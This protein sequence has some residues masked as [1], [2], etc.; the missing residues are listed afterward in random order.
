MT[1]PTRPRST[2]PASRRPP[3]LRDPGYAPPN[4]ATQAPQRPRAANPPTVLHIRRLP[5]GWSRRHLADRFL[6]LDGAEGVA[7]AFHGGEN[8]GYLTFCTQAQAL[9]ACAVVSVALGT[10]APPP[11]R[12]PAA[13]HCVSHGV[14]RDLTVHAR[15]DALGEGRRDGLPAGNA[16]PA[17]GPPPSHGGG[18]PAPYSRCRTRA[19]TSA[20]CAGTGAFPGANGQRGRRR[21]PPPTP[22]SAPPDTPDGAA[23]APLPG[24]GPCGARERGGG[25][26][27]A[28][29]FWR[30][31]PCDQC[32]PQQAPP[33][34]GGATTE[35]ALEEGRV[36]GHTP[37]EQPSTTSPALDTGAPRAAEAPPPPPHRC[38]CIPGHGHPAGWPPGWRRGRPQP[39]GALTASGRV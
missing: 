23:S 7:E 4:R 15:H 25:P 12:L 22:K 29:G 17:R 39:S 24:G 32:P 33:E 11:G 6:W 10:V 34:A 16:P 20:T 9:A 26:R 31:S 2:V 13:V 8:H 1:S 5:T 21:R 36:P 19:A 30:P 28:A 37:G 27:A 3:G 14:V 18:C 38:G 35:P